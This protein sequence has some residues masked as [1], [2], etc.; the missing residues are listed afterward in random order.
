[1]AYAILAQAILEMSLYAIF[2]CPVGQCDYIVS[3]YFIGSRNKMIFC[4]PDFVWIP[5]LFQFFPFFFPLTKYLDN[6]W[7][8]N[9]MHHYFIYS[10]KHCFSWRNAGFVR[11]PSKYF[12][13]NCH[14]QIELTI[15]Y[16][17]YPLPVVDDGLKLFAL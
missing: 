4:Y 5:Y 1:M 8:R 12:L 15:I 2:H 3:R 6:S 11:C 16:N 17:V 7:S 10:C 14:S 13:C 9:I